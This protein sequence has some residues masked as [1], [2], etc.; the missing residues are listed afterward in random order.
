MM[1]VVKLAKQTRVSSDTIR[2]YV[3]VGLLTPG[4]NQDNNYQLFDAQDAKRLKFINDAKQLGFSLKEIR[5]IIEQSERGNSPCPTVR[6]I[7]Q[8]RIEEN[9]RKLEQLQALQ[10]RMESAL[11][12]WSEMPDG[13]PDGHCICHLIESAVTTA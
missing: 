2:Y 11:S 4:R 9:R 1:T 7:I 8:D 6:K 13:E 12:Q 3:R 10:N 5:T